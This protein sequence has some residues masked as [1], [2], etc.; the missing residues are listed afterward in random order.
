MHAND[1]PKLIGYG[2]Y[3]V[4]FDLKSGLRRAIDQF[5]EEDNLQLNP[6]FQRGRVWTT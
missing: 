1:I 5:I 4:D 6:D 2:N 3:V